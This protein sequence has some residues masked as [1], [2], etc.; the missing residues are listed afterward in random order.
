MYKDQIKQ[1]GEI[2][3]LWHGEFQSNRVNK[4]LHK[5][6]YKATFKLGNIL[7]S[8]EEEKKSLNI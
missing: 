4:K 3:M 2:K 6:E 1:K 5:P 7:F 8:Q